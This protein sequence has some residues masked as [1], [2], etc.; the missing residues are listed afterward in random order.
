MIRQPAV[1]GRFYP[2]DPRRLKNLIASFLNKEEKKKDKALACVLPHAGYLYSAKVAAMTL[3]SI[4]IP[5]TC[6]ILGPNHTG[7][8]TPAGIMTKGQWQTPFGVMDID[9]EVARS[10]L[11]RSRY[12]REDEVAHTYEHSIEVQL[13]LIHQ[14]KGG[15]FRFVPVILA[16]EEKLMYKDIAHSIAAAVRE[17][18]KDILIIASSD[19]THYEPQKRAMEKDQKAI[20]AILALDENKLEDRI[21]RHRISMCG[22]MPAI[23]AIM[24]AKQLGAK[25]AR[26]KAYQTSGDI[27]GDYSSVVGY[28][29]IAIY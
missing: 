17:A 25:T 3:S 27:S 8:G 16:S 15:D 13:P 19:M 5:E 29:G 10:L 20:E 14:I 21:K 26:L 12:L 24:A 2:S 23:V 22:Y 4:T 6:I 11:D 28:A 1:A 7:F 9:T 18:K